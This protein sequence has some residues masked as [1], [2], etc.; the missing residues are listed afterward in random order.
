MDA[1]WVPGRWRRWALGLVALAAL[2]AGLVVVLRTPVP[3]ASGPPTAAGSGEAAPHTHL[4]MAG[5][6]AMDGAT[7]PVGGTGPSAGGYSLVPTRSVVQPGRAENFSFQIRGA[8]GRPVT[9]FAV[10]HDQLM[11]LILVRRDL[12]GFQHLHPAMAPDGT[13]SVPLTLPSPGQYRAYADFTLVAPGGTLDALV[14]GVDLTAPAGPGPG[15]AGAR[16]TSPLPPPAVVSTVDGLTVRYEGTPAI[17]VVQPLLFAVYRAGA[18]VT[19]QPYLGAY[20]HLVVLRQADLGYLHIH[21]EPALVDGRVKFW[22]AL[23]GPGSYRMYAQLRVAGVV[24]TA[25]FTLAVR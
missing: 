7:V 15:G 3:A 23:P 19:P 12:T 11:H 9:R 2:A 14:L 13:W 20:G 24:H 8:D 22:L 25:E 18:P 4:P 10:V 6:A 16:G 21:P 17:G 5:M 1:F